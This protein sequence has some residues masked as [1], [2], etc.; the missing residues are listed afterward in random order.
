VDPS[1]SNEEYRRAVRT[2]RE[3]LSTLPMVEAAD[4]KRREENLL[5]FDDHMSLAAQSAAEH[6]RS[7]AAR[8][9]KVSSCF[10]R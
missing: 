4:R 1:T 2:V 5:T 9:C 6:P 10:T 3:R 8:T 7:R